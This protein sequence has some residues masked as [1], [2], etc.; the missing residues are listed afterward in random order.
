[1]EHLGPFRRE[2]KERANIAKMREESLLL[3]PATQIALFKGLVRTTDHGV[4]E[5]AVERANRI[6]WDVRS[7]IWRDIIV[8]AD[9]TIISIKEAYG[10]TADLITYLI[11]ASRMSEEE[12]ER[13]RMEYDVS[14][15]FNYDTPSVRKPEELP[16]PIPERT[17]GLVS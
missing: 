5:R 15:G 8:R 11:V 12:T 16:Q 3:R 2:L 13:L 17:P 6:D 10:R 7:S 9:S 14:R 4:L 1:L